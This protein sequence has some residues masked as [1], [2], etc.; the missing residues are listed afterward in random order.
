MTIYTAKEL[1]D[2]MQRCIAEEYYKPDQTL[3][4]TIWVAK[5]V[6]LR[7]RWLRRE[8]SAHHEKWAKFVSSINR[9]LYESQ[10]ESA[11]ATLLDEWLT[12]WEEENEEE[13]GEDDEA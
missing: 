10:L 2:E 6:S 7:P 3:V 5:D 4:V 1:A 12:E 13:E 8:R 9:G 11:Q